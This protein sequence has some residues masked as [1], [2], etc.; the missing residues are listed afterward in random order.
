MR[1]FEY[2][3]FASRLHSV[4][5]NQNRD[6]INLNCVFTVILKKYQ[7]RFSHNSK[8]RVLSLI[9]QNDKNHN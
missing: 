9:I 6:T 8:T 4:V 5:N 7:L 2:D 3:M 1:T